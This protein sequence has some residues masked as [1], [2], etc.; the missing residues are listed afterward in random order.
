MEEEDGANW[1]MLSNCVDLLLN[2]LEEQSA[3]NNHSDRARVNCPA[4]CERPRELSCNVQSIDNE[5]TNGI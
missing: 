2:I 3:A 4:S 1:R 5:M